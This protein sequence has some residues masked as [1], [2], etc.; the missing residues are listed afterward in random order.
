MIIKLCVY[1]RFLS[2]FQRDSIV[3]M[4]LDFSARET[5]VSAVVGV[6]AQPCLMDQEVTVGEVILALLHN[7]ILHKIHARL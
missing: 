2:L 1:L 3:I 4:L 5:A 6:T 7:V